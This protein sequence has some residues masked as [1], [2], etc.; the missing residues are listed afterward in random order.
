MTSQSMTEYF[1]VEKKKKKKKNY[2]VEKITQGK[3]SL[4]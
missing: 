1:P 2:I 4:L 3:N